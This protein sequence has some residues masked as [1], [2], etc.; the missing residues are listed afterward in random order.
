[1]TP[2][3]ANVLCGMKSNIQE[4]TDLRRHLKYKNEKWTLSGHR[5]TYTQTETEASI[6]N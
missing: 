2:N 4:M 5:P 3:S 6:H 1:M